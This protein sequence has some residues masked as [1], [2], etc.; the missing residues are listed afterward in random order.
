MFV[1]LANPIGFPDVTSSKNAH[2]QN[3]VSLLIS[4][5]GKLKYLYP[6]AA[7]SNLRRGGQERNSSMVLLHGYNL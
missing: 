5:V 1:I 2:C 6:T 3:G 4:E 7:S